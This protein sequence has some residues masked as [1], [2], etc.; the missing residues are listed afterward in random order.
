M[1]LH[2]GEDTVVLTKDIIVIM[3]MDGAT[4][5]KF[6]RELLRKGELD[7]NI[8]TVSS[9]LPRTIIITLDNKIYLS[10]VSTSTL[11]K[12]SNL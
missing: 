2:L 11:L 6:S 7:G 12:K 3:D 5:S 1:F 8:V 10:P 4:I 9:L